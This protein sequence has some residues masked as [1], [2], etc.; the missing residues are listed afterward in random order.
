MTNQKHPNI[1]FFFTDDQRFDTIHALGNEAISTPNIDRLVAEGTTFTHAHIPCGTSGAVC[2]PSRAMLHSGRSLF[3]LEAEGQSIPRDH[4]TMGET[5]Q[6]NGYR[7]FGTGKWHNGKEA[8]ARSFT[9]GAEIYFGGMFDHWNV[10]AYN[11]DPS[12]KYD[13]VLPKCNDPF[14]S[15]EVTYRPCDHVHAGKH[16]TELFADATIDFLNTCEQ[17]TPFLAYV[18]FMAPHD[19]RT[20]PKKYHDMYDPETIELPPN[21]CG[22]HPFDTGALRIRDER[23]AE[24]PRSPNEVRTHIAE[25]YAMITHVDAE[26][27]RVLEHLDASGQRDNTIIVL[28]GDNG[29]A[30]GQHGLMGKQNCYEHSVRV[31]LLFSGPGIPQN[32]K[33]PAYVYLFDLFRTLCEL[34]DVPVPDSVEGKSLVPAL[35]QPDAV[36]RDRLYFAYTEH[37]RAIKKGSLK[38]IEYATGDQRNTQL[39]DVDKDPWELTNLAG[40]REHREDVDLL[41]EELVQLRDAWDD[42]SHPMGQTFWNRV[43]NE[44]ETCG[45]E[46]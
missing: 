22:G 11:F 1:L 43:K 32:Q 45:E 16:S 25:Y 4:A 27:G 42:P 8:Y 20:M 13:A 28:A 17:D 33:C 41:R 26:I 37:Q 23:L 10:P 21:F 39:F 44:F 29:L 24:F 14:N 40:K 12:G 19:P 9:D 6:K 38:L 2:M 30:V 5:F 36:I 34:A 18:S 3:H 15:N 35:K 46:S 31:P 7:T